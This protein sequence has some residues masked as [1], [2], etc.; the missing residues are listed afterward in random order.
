[1]NQLISSSD[2]FW[3]SLGQAILHSFWQGLVFLALTALG[4]KAIK[5][6]QPGLRYWLAAGS[7]IAFLCSFVITF[8]YFITVSDPS[9]TLILFESPQAMIQA[10]G[11][12][13]LSPQE[14]KLSD[15]VQPSTIVYLWLIGF[16]IFSLRLMIS[17][18]Y[19]HY[20]G[21]DSVL[22][23]DSE[24]YRMLQ[25]LKSKMKVSGNIEL[26]WSKKVDTIFT[27][28]YFKPVIIWPLALVNTLNPEEVEV[29][30]AHELAHI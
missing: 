26:R 10:L 2:I 22:D 21:K 20:L 19:V 29:I 12:F 6:D 24:V 30:L 14:W 27:Y 3:E 23:N 11:G 18:G 1:M 4:L 7:I 9:S 17:Y 13:S 16:T 8:L 15:L 5:S 28:G 25:K